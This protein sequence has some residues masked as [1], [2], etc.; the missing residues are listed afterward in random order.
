[1]N[2]L[3]SIVA[4]ALLSAALAPQPP[5]K[6][7]RGI[8]PLRSTRADVERLLGPPETEAGSVYATAGER[9]SVSYS[10]RPCDYGWQVAPDTVIS[11]FVYPKQPLKL[12]DLKLD[13]KKHERRKDLHLAVHYYLDAEGGINY[14]VDST[15]GL[16]TGV[17]YYP[18]LKSKAPRC[19][20]P[21][22]RPSETRPADGRVRRGRR[23][24]ARP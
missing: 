12:A 24:P 2:P 10:G 8:E 6:G 19:R 15:T 21:A 13:E 11:F 7:W 3:L 9:V 14:T 17:E 16:V 20:P 22:A 4:C 18:P 23:S 5:G 1:M